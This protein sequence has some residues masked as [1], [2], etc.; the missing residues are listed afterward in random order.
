MQ[1]T[2]EDPQVNTYTASDG[3]QF[4]CVYV[5]GGDAV[6]VCVCV[7]VCVM[8]MLYV[9]VYDEDAVCVCVWWRCSV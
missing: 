8:G 9:C 4:V 2:V 6:C 1:R 3:S 7:C 5:Y